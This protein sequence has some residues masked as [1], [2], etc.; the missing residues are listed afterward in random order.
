MQIEMGGQARFL[1]LIDGCVL[2]GWL[3]RFYRIIKQYSVHVFSFQPINHW[4]FFNLAC[5]MTKV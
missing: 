1:D 5:Y 2:L 3:F 4:L